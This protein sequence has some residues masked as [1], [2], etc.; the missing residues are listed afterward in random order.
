MKRLPSRV[1]LIPAYNQ[2]R[3]GIDL[4]DMLV[5]MYETPA[6]SRRWYIPLFGYILD[7]CI[8]NFSLVYKR[9]CGLLNEKPAPL[10]SFCLFCFLVSSREKEKIFRVILETLF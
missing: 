9:D 6:K 8:S 1:S 4:Y 3:G 2:H 10:K 7:L 5:L